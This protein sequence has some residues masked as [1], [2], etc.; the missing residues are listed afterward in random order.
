MVNPGFPTYLLTGF[1]S[2]EK[3]SH[4]NLPRTQLPTSK[5]GYNV[6]VRGATSLLS[7][8]GLANLE[9]ACE[10]HLVV[11]GTLVFEHVTVEDG[12]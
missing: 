2:S 4:V 11:S 8:S 10:S 7:Q 9:R 3:Y 5:A 1:K 12:G 6:L